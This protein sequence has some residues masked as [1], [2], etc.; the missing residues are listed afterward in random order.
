MYVDKNCSVT[1]I[2]KSM[3]PYRLWKFSILTE[4]SL[5][6]S[7]N[8]LSLVLAVGLS[9]LLLRGHFILSILHGHL[10]TTDIHRKCVSGR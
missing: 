5:S 4:I 1:T 3:Y 8:L 2:G 10:E 6:E 7:G 9:F